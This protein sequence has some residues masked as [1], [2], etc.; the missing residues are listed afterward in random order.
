M[1]KLQPINAERVR[2]THREIRLRVGGQAPRTDAI[3]VSSV[4]AAAENDD[5]RIFSEPA[6]EASARDL[7]V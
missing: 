2:S 7:I 3:S 1:A 4:R 5:D 6:I